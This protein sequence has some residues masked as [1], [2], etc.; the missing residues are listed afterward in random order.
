[1]KKSLIILILTLLALQRKQINMKKYI[2]LLLIIL[3]TGCTSSDIVGVEIVAEHDIFVIDGHS[4]QVSYTDDNTNENII[5]KSDQKNYTNF[6]GNFNFYFTIENLTEEAQNID[7]V[8]YVNNGNVSDISKYNGESEEE[9]IVF[10][11]EEKITATSV[12]KKIIVGSSIL[13][14]TEWNEENITESEKVKPQLVDLNDKVK[15]DTKS[16]KDKEANKKFSVYLEKDEQVLFKGVMQ[17]EQV[18]GK[19]EF[20]IE[21]YGE[22]SG[23]GHLD[24][25]TDEIT[26]NGYNTAELGTQ[27]GWGTTYDVGQFNVQE[28]V[29]AEGAKAIESTSTGDYTDRDVTSASS[30]TVYYSTYRSGA[31]YSEVRFYSGTSRTAQI[32]LNSADHKIY[33]WDGGTKT[34]S[35][36]TFSDNIWNRVGLAFTGTTFNININNGSFT[37]ADYA[38][39]DATGDIDN[40][41][42]YHTGAGTTYFD[43]ISPNYSAG[44]VVTAPRQE[45]VMWFN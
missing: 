23:Y 35:G 7:L 13:Y 26:F 34:D 15:I 37:T 28:T 5:I 20:F 4:K 41:F 38:Y 1:M 32:R 19:D 11:L 33:I 3:L 22:K 36:L 10:K 17:K 2:I 21:A 42:I 25:W 30:G 43:Y 14:K 27:D 12:E 9:I 16:T 44:G 18:G 6:A 39:R 24:P 31:G 8:F 40:I 29:T 45:E